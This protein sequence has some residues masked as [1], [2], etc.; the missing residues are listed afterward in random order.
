MNWTRAATAVAAAL[1][2]I[3][4]TIVVFVSIRK[5]GPAPIEARA[6]KIETPVKTSAPPDIVQE[7]VTDVPPAGITEISSRKEPVKV[8]KTIVRHTPVRQEPPPRFE[9]EGDFYPVTFAGGVEDISGGGQVVRT[10]IPR[11]SLIA[12][13]LDI[14]LESANQKI[15]TDLLVGQDGVIRGVRIVK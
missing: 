3:A 6:I 11:S 5:N 9:A 4:A 7:P 12:M 14:P 1:I 8:R 15:K 13:G 2:F 10:E